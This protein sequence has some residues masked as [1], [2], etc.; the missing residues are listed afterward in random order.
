MKVIVVEDGLAYLE[1]GQVVVNLSGVPADQRAHKMAL[2][3]E[4]LGG[5]GWEI[6]DRRGASGRP[7]QDEVG[8]R[9]A[10]GSE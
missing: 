10:E 8:G 4:T 2:A 7:S 5:Y 9:E 1:D 3:L 6:D